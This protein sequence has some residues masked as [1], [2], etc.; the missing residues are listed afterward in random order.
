LS[1]VQLQGSDPA[2]TSRPIDFHPDST[3]VQAL[4]AQAALLPYALATFAIGLP[5]FGWVCSYAQDRLWLIATLLLFAINWAAFYALVDR[6]KRNPH[7]R[8]DTA[9]RTRLHVLGGLLWAV[10]VAQIS[11]LGLSAG[12][13]REPVLLLAAAMAAVCVVFSSPSLPTLLIVA[14][15]ASAPPILALY[16]NDATRSDGRLALA[17]IALGPVSASG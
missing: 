4:D 7:G 13:A 12:P 11:V 17:A 8:A 14:P 10:A 15:A 1:S 9:L 5:I 6:I 3:A 2:P 16:A